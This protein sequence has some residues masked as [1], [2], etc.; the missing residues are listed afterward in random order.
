M[1]PYVIL[2]VHYHK[3]YNQSDFFKWNWTYVL[4][5]KSVGKSQI[6]TFLSLRSLMCIQSYPKLSRSKHNGNHKC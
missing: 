4:M 1:F 3:I 2:R 5:N 6:T